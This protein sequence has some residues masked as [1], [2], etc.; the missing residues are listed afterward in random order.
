MNIILVYFNFLHDR[1]CSAEQTL[2][3]VPVEGRI[4]IPDPSRRVGNH[5]LSLNGNEYMTITKTDGSF[6]FDNIPTGFVSV[7][8]KYVIDIYFI[9]L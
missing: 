2:L 8:T 7:Q 6:T 5:I 3:T 4:V 1:F 9:F